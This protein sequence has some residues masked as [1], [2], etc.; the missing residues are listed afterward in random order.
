MS[1]REPV[2]YLHGFASSPASKKAR[3]FRERF[4]AL[5]VPFEVPDL[6]RGDFEHLTLTG[7]LEVVAQT[8]GQRKVRLMGSSMGGY[9]AALF[10][11]ANPALVD[12][13]VLMAPA[14]DFASRWRSR[15]GEP[16]F[17]EWQRT[18]MLPVFHY[19][20][21]RPANLGFGLYSDALAFVVGIRTIKCLGVTSDN[22]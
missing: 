15:L 13:A 14:F 11:S 4:E 16:V 6:A 8:V 12:R 10:A 21:G 1:A 2:V 20:D 17:T 18:G 3:F 5:G 7:Q 22:Q 9:L 19:G